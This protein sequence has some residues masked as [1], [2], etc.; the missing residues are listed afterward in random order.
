MYVE[1]L[2]LYPKGTYK[3]LFA[4]SQAGIEYCMVNLCTGSQFRSRSVWDMIRGIEGDLAAN[5]FPQCMLQYRSWGEDAAVESIRKA[6]HVLSLGD[7]RGESRP[8]LFRTTFIVKVLFRQ[9][10]TWQGTIQ[11]IEGR[12]TKQ[13]RSLNELLKLMDEALALS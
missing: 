13:Y 5:K 11:W 9:N 4:Q 7:A 10:A 2:A 1:Q 6:N 8:E 12:Q 3:V